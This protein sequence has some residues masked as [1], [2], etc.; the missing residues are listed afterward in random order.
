MHSVGEESHQGMAIKPSAGA[1]ASPPLRCT[2]LCPAGL[3][4]KAF[5]EEIGNLQATAQVKEECPMTS[6]QVKGTGCVPGRAGGGDGA[7]RCSAALLLELLERAG[8]EI[9]NL[10]LCE[11]QLLVPCFTPEQE[12]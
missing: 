11:F 8:A 6:V 10:L 4:D 3:W 1:R 7:V 12:K 5:Q 9:I 2:G